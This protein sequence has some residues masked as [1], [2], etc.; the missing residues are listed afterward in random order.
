M[1]GSLLGDATLLPTTS[2]HCF[3]VNHGIAQSPYVDWKWKVLSSYVRS[4]PRVCRNGYYFRTVTH[5][6]LS[7][8]RR[9][10]YPQGV[11]TVPIDLLIKQF[12]ELSLAVWI[13]DDGASDG[14]QLRINSQSFSQEENEIL[15]SLLR[16]KLGLDVRLNV[17]KGRYRLRFT[18]ASMERLKTF[19]RPYI[20]P[21]MLYKLP[22]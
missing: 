14:K 16:A 22:P 20:L 8:L 9:L 17:D 1:I 21:S 4:M 6:E 19:V 3:R 15:A 11:K 2:G 13:M 18:A 10:F 5:P 7:N 12:S